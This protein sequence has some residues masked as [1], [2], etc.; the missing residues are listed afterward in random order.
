LT[1]GDIEFGIGLKSFDQ[2][3]DCL[4]LVH[5]VGIQKDDDVSLAHFTGFGFAVIITRW[6]IKARF[7]IDTQTDP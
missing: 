2:C 6:K 1:G 5:T 3:L 7:F 4:T